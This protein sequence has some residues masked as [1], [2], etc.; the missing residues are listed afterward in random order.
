M[1]DDLRFYKF[2]I[3][4]YLSLNK[5]L[6]G[7]G[8]VPSICFILIIYIKNTHNWVGLMFYE[9]ISLSLFIIKGFVRI[10]LLF[11]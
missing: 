7:G 8:F 3:I 11:S 1:S 9:L 4:Q 2:K 5:G 10:N 6:L